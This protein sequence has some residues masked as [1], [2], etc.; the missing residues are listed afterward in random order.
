MLQCLDTYIFMNIRLNRRVT[1]K[2]TKCRQKPALL[3]VNCL[4]GL[5]VIV[6]YMMLYVVPYLKMICGLGMRSILNITL[7]HSTVEKYAEEM[8]KQ[9]LNILSTLKLKYESE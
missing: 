3:Q 1:S 8:K 7:F 5:Y 2:R 6:I 9:G 4:I